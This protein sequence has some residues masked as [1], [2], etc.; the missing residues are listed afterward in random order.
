VLSMLAAL[1][2]VIVTLVVIASSGV[3]SAAGGVRG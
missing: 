2:G 3:F 1:I